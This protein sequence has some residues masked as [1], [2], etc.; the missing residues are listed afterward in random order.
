MLTILRLAARNLW[1]NR[2]RTLITLSAVIIG[3]AVVVFMTGFTNGF[4]QMMVLDTTQAKTGALQVHLVGYA[5][6]NESLPTKLN[7]PDDGALEQKIRAV[8]GVTSVAPRIAFGGMVSNGLTSAMF[9][10]G[11]IDPAREYSVAPRARVKLIS[12]RPLEVA[13]RNG[14]LIGQEL[15]KSLKGQEGKGLTLLAQGPSGAQNVL[16]GVVQGSPNLTNP[17]EGKRILTVPLAFAQDLL[18]MKGQITEYAVAIDDLSR[19]DAIAEELRRAVGPGYEVQ[20]WVQL[21]P[22]IKDIIKRQQFVLGI[23]SVVLF[24]IVVTGIV[25]TMLMSAF[26]RVREVG[27]MMALGLRRRAILALFLFEAII[28]GL[29][30]GAGGATV[31]GALVLILG[32]RGVSFSPP[33]G[34]RSTLFPEVG[35]P[36]VLMTIGVAFAGAVLSALYPAWKSSRLRPV[37][38]LRAP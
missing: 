27:T 4:T 35:I 6:S 37:D 38:A 34:G 30:G 12:G 10:G 29:I 13:D 32:A 31:G 33:G 20:T 36:F 7:F 22:F 5:D 17:F 28:L 24:I 25:N 14:L 8:R 11:A 21:A 15:A 3:V 18:G 2:R 16:E 23:V 1:R 9:I 19:V 26:E